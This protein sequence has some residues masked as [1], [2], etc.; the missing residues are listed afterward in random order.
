MICQLINNHSINQRPSSHQA[1]SI[2]NINMNKSRTL[3]FLKDLLNKI[4]IRRRNVTCNHTISMS[5]GPRFRVLN[6]DQSDHH[7]NSIV[8]I[9]GA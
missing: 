9:K 8:V 5:T 3:D 6:H 4:E 1:I 2:I 7:A